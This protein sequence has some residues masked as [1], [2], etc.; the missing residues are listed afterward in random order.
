MSILLRALLSH[1]LHV[2]IASDI[3]DFNIRMSES[4][5]TSGMSDDHPLVAIAARIQREKEIMVGKAQHKR[6]VV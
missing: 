4:S 6:A 2:C 5:F 1:A 3:E